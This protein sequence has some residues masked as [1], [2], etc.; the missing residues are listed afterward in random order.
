MISIEYWRSL[1]YRPLH[2]LCFLIVFSASYGLSAQDVDTV[3]VEGDLRNVETIAMVSELDPQKA[4]MYSAVLPGLGQAYNKDYWK[5][6][7][8]YGG[9]II[10]LHFINQNHDLYNTFN[11][12]LLA[13]VD[14]VPETTNPFDRYNESSLQNRRDRYKR[15]RDFMIIVGV[16]YYL[17]NVVEANVSAHLKEFDVNEDLSLKLKPSFQPLPGQYP[18]AGV[19]VALTF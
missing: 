4:A 9:G 8:I 6:P 12:A 19:G 5:I 10:I 15:D 1:N 2:V 7:V 14:G 17:L 11:N 3:N 18:A 16:I 13:E